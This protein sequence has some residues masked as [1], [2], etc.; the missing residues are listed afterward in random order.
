MCA[1]SNG[2]ISGLR[3][4]DALTRILFK[5]LMAESGRLNQVEASWETSLK[6][7]EEVQAEKAILQ[8]QLEELERECN[9][10]VA[11]RRTVRDNLTRLTDAMRARDEAH[12]ARMRPIHNEVQALEARESSLRIR[13]TERVEALAKNQIES[14][15]CSRVEDERARA[16]EIMKKLRDGHQT[17]IDQME[18]EV[19]RKLEYHTRTV[20]KDTGCR[21]QRELNLVKRELAQMEYLV[22]SEKEAVRAA[23]EAVEAHKYLRQQVRNAVHTKVQHNEDPICEVEVA[24]ARDTLRQILIDYPSLAAL[25]PGVAALDTIDPYKKEQCIAKAMEHFVTSSVVPHIELPCSTLVTAYE[26]T[27]RQMRLVLMPDDDE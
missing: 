10:A 16:K 8:A 5:E 21:T 27:L 7:L 1:S 15:V 19:K 17:K 9:Q 13:S 25:T 12:H 18:A 20:I 23:R 26:T 22:E 3:D 14:M 2:S 24:R 4:E 6:H 11:I